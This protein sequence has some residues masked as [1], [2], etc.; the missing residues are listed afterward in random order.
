[1]EDMANPEKNKNQDYTL[2]RD[3]I[4]GDT[5]YLV[6]FNTE[7]TVT[8]LPDNKGSITA[9]AGM[10][11][12]KVPVDT[13][14]LVE[15]TKQDKIRV[16][17]KPMGSATAQTTKAPPSGSGKL[18]IR[19]LDSQE[20]MLELDRFIDRSVVQ[21]LQTIT[22]VHGKGTGVLREAVSQNLRTNKYIANYRLGGFGEGGDGATIAE[23]K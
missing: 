23:L 3:L 4:V 19:G 10:L 22:I 12:L 6:D 11:D 18:D 20:A 15:K 14:R 16:N 17:G 2:P 5:V 13:V 8:S 1:M 21:R 7:G 9:K